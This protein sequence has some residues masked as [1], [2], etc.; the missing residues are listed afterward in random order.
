M[1]IKH[2]GSVSSMFPKRLAVNL[3]LGALMVALLLCIPLFQSTSAGFALGASLALSSSEEADDFTIT[4]PLVMRNLA[5]VLT[6]PVLEVIDNGDGDGN[7]TVSWSTSAGA[8][9]YTLQEADTADFTSPSIVYEGAANSTD[10]S[11]QYVGTYY[12]RVRASS[13]LADSDWSNVE[14]VEVSVLPD[15][16]ATGMWNGTTSQGESSVII[17]EVQDLPYC[18]IPE[19]VI[20]TPTTFGFTITFWDSCGTE[21]NITNLNEIPIVNSR[22]ELSASSGTYKGE[23]TSYTTASGTFSYNNGDCWASGTWTAQLT[24]PGAFSKTSPVNGATVYPPGVTLTWAAS[25]LAESYEYCFDATND[26]ACTTWVNTGTTREASIA[27]LSPSTTY[28]WQVRASNN[29]GSTYANGDITADWSFTTNSG[30]PGDFVKLTPAD[31]ATDRPPNSLTL[32]WGNSS[33]ADAY[34][35]CYDTTDDDACTNWVDTGTTSQAVIT[36]LDAYATI[37][38]QVRATNS[39]GETYANGAATA[40]WSFAT[41]SGLPG[42]FNKVSPVDGATS[43]T[44]EDLTLD[45]G[46]SSYVDSYAYCYDTTDDDACTN[47]VETGTTSQ[48][49][50]SGLDDLTRFYWQVRATNGYGDTYANVAATAYW[51]FVT[52]NELTGVW[53]QQTPAADWPARYGHSTVLLPDGSL[54]L[55][56]GYDGENRLNDVWRSTDQGATWTPLTAAAEWT[57]RRYHASAVLPDGSIVLVGGDDDEAG[58]KNDVWR[59]TDKGATWTQQTAAALWTDRCFHTIGVLSDG[60]ILLMGGLS[61]NFT[62]WND[63]WRSTNQGA[64]WTLLVNHAEWR[65]RGNHTTVLLQ[66][67]SIVLMGGYGFI[68]DDSVGKLRDVWRSTNQGAT[69]VQMNAS[70]PWAA[71]EG[72]TSVVLP[73]GSILLMGGSSSASYLNDVWRSKDYGATWAQLATASWAARSGHNSL[74][75]LPDG[76]IVLL[77]GVTSSGATNDVWR[78]VRDE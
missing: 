56:G 32:D 72:H 42:A 4:L 46:N 1:F 2:N 26:D 23:F 70:A 39:Y 16:P 10:I 77:G 31:S 47:W 12:Y 38:W 22:F 41:N 15:C 68:D 5:S 13:S 35:Y 49:L 63:V 55:M 61:S 65:A 54:V 75:T 8:T 67:G 53:T 58:Y 19:S 66:D 78:F 45:W 71:R 14:P 62:L 60:S 6:P 9:T 7:Y 51:S 64:N 17:F 48:A 33:Y 30:V 50:I 24:P 44:T 59:S 3:V 11:G 76:S 18:R 36:G 69:W 37:Y 74:T 40:Y 73:D 34:A 20:G 25:S 27:G 43:Q 28:Y 29:A 21:R 57:A 52:Q